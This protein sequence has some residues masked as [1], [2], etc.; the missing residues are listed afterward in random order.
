MGLLLEAVSKPHL[1]PDSCVAALFKMLTYFRVC[2]AFSSG[3]A[4]LSGLIRGFETTSKI[5]RFATEGLTLYFKNMRPFSQIVIRFSSGHKAFPFDG[6]S[7]G[8]KE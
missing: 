4:L 3:C 6:S 5:L 2:C 8:G 1:R 7:T